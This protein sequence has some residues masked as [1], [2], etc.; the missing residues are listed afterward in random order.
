MKVLAL[1]YNRPGSRI[2]I[3]IEHLFAQARRTFDVRVLYRSS[4]NAI[5]TLR[6]VRAVLDFKPDILYCFTPGVPVYAAM[7]VQKLRGGKTVLHYDDF[8][9]LYL[10]DFGTNRGPANPLLLSIVRFVEHGCLRSADRLLLMNKREAYYLRQW[11]VR[12]KTAV[13][14]HGAD[15]RHLR[16]KNVSSLRTRIGLANVMTVGMVATFNYA[17]R[18]DIFFGW[19]ILEAIRELSDV[20]VKAVFVGSGNAIDIMKERARRYGIADKVVFVG[21]KHYREL[22]DYYNL[23]DVCT[24]AQP[25]HPS[26]EIKTPLKFPEYLA[27]GR[28]VVVSSTARAVTPFI[29]SNGGILQYRGIKDPAYPALLAAHLRTLVRNRRLLKRGLRGRSIARR[30]FDYDRL[31][32]EMTTFLKAFEASGA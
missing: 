14:P 5:D 15:L 23:I 21:A 4:N 13:L 30:Y 26:A 7:K 3:Y 12:T 24:L 28:Y 29:R 1:V 16:P 18:Y 11:G 31:A 27:C 32:A 2:S 10:R 8:T 6:F 25:Q 9:Y 22:T 19:D 17:K 20:P